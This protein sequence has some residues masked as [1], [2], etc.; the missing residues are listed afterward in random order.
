[1][2]RVLIVDDQ[3]A[4]LRQLRRLLALAGLEVIGEATDIP[5]AERLARTHHPDIAIVDL[6]LPGINGL[7]GARRLKHIL[8]QLRIYLVSAFAD[9]ASIYAASARAA[10]ADAFLSKDE[11][12][13][14]IIQTWKEAP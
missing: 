6:M 8:P 12:E 13:L 1:M 7:E 3:P 9:H 5:T 10:G 4:F 2:I 11:L 14:K